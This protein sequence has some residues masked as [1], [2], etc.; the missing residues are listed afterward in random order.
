[1]NQ[2]RMRIL[3]A[4]MFTDMVG[5]TALMQEDEQK[6][7]LLRDRH[8]SVLEGAIV[9]HKGRV[10][11]YYG[12]GTLS[13]FGSVIEAVTSALEIQQELKKEPQV[14]LRI[15][16]HV[17]DIVYEDEGVYGDGVNIASRIESL[18][19]SGGILISEK[20]FDEIKNHRALPAK[21]L[22]EFRLKNVKRPIEIFALINK[23]LT[24][25]S[26]EDLPSKT[27]TSFKSI[28][29]L[30]F[31]NM[32][33]DP[34]NEYFSDGI[35]EELI[36][37]LTKVDGLLVTSRTSSFAFKGKTEDVR[38]IGSQLNVST[39]LEGSVRKAGDRVRIAAQLINTADGYHVWSEVYNRNLEDIFEV[40]DEISRT[41]TNKLREKLTGSEMRE[42][43]VKSPTRNLDA[44]NLYLKGLFYWNKWTP[45]DFRKAITCFE[46]AIHEEPSFA[47]PHSSLSNC[48]VVLGSTGQISPK[49]AYPRAKESALKA[50][51][52]DSN[53][54]ESHISLGVVKLFFDWDLDSALKLFQKA[55]ELNPSAAAAHLTFAL[56]LDAV[57]KVEEAVSEMEMA[58]QLDP[59]SLQINNCLG[60]AYF[61]AERLDEAMEQYEK[62]LELDPSFRAALEGKGMVYLVKGEIDQS[63]KVLEEYQKQTK[64]PLKGVTALGIAYAR[65]GKLEEAHECLRKLKERERTEIDISLSMDFACLYAELKD[66]DKAFYYLEKTVEE[67]VG[68]VFLRAHP[69]WK[70]LRTDP[71]FKN[72]MKK[73]GF[74]D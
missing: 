72:L 21:S 47:L 40:Q 33:A 8:R 70:D 42:P 43:L 50:L 39:V 46:E 10:V 2:E 16:L 56:Y 24:V 32:S 30:P 68:L 23:G 66:L 28:A 61:F 74:K 73:I 55:L 67:R 53:L 26:A 18:S 27:D 35:S 49:K 52:L 38:Q 31:V 51:E 36:N 45:D 58:V 48:Y 63:I 9:K 57:G 7:K 34:E 60:D 20:V 62:T 29:V 65:A 5:Y 15:G 64:H 37:A 14:P 13:V 6:A 17:G 11:Q 25:P 1:M 12:D 71:R 22:G 44:Y 69:M 41:I 54:A 3:A 59:L 4:I 19:V